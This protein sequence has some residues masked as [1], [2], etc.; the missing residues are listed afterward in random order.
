MSEM[1]KVAGRANMDKITT[2]AKTAK[3][4][5][6]TK[7]GLKGQNDQNCRIDPNIVNDR[8]EKKGRNCQSSQNCKNCNM[9]KKFKRGHKGQNDQ[10]IKKSK[11]DRMFKKGQNGQNE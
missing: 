6:M 3:K 8:D 10:I 5:I 11:S 2:L 9:S 1:T 7:I 4:A